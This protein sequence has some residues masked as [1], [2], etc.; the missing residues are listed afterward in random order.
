ME[1]I[2]SKIQQKIMDRSNAFEERTNWTKDK[3]NI[4][5]ED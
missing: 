5:N 2:V 4:Y 3:Y 1:D